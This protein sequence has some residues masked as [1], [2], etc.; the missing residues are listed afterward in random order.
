VSVSGVDCIPSEVSFSGSSSRVRVT[1]LRLVEALVV[2]L[3]ACA[4]FV[5]R[6]GMG[7]TNDD[8]SLVHSCTGDEGMDQGDARQHRAYL[9]VTLMGGKERSRG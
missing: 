3:A 9:L 6:R 1:E 4:Q 8:S 2:I 7:C 5:S